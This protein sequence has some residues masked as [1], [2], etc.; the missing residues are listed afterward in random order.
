MNRGAV[1]AKPFS[2]LMSQWVSLL[3]IILF[4]EIRDVEVDMPTEITTLD[5]YRV[6]L[7]VASIFASVLF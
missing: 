3:L 4:N 5:P 1:L 7:Q 6:R 2:C